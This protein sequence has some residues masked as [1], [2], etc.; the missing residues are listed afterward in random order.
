MLDNE[1]IKLFAG[2]SNRP[3]AEKISKYLNLPLG[4]LQIARFSDGECYVKYEESVRGIDAFIIQPTCPPVD[5]NIMELLI[6]IDALKRASA[7][8]ICAVIPYYG[9][10]CQEKKDAP[11]EPITAKLVAD[12]LTTAG[13]NRVITMDLHAGAIQGFFNIP[14]DHLTAIP[15]FSNYYLNKGIENTVFVSPDEGRAKHVRAVSSRV[16]APLAVGYKYHPDHHISSV[17]HLAGEVKGKTPI[18]VEDMIRTGGSISECVDALLYYGCNPEI[19][20]AATHGL[21]TDRC[22]NRLNRPEIKEVLVTDSVPMPENAPDKFKVLSVAPMFAEA[23]K[24]VHQN[25]SITSLF[26]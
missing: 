7:K 17:T 8:T 11:R 24:R 12:I 22:F 21:L 3:L 18:I 20:V 9:Y 25:Q 23:I 19:Y 5:I 6:L 15:A 2:T 26:D 16:G 10:A 14:V 1:K 13:A 4:N